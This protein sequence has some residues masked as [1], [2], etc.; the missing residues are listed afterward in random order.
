MKY[1]RSVYSNLAT[2]S[3]V[4]FLMSIID[5]ARI[6]NVKNNYCCQ[7]FCIETLETVVNKSGKKLPSVVLDRRFRTFLIAMK[8]VLVL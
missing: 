8:I 6:A 1:P 7:A 3:V 2:F 5:G 4:T